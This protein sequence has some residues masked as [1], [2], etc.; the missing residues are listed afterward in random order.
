M[1]SQD[2]QDRGGRVDVLF[3]E[4]FLH[5]RL[6]NLFHGRL[7]ADLAEREEHP[8]GGA[9]IIRSHHRS[10]DFVVILIQPL[11]EYHGIGGALRMTTLCCTLLAVMSSSQQ[12][13]ALTFVL[14]QLF[15]I[16]LPAKDHVQ[17][18]Q[19]QICG[20]QRSLVQRGVSVGHIAETSGD[21]C[22]EVGRAFGSLR[23]RDDFIAKARSSTTPTGTLRGRNRRDRL[24]RSN[25]SPATAGTLLPRLYRGSVR[26]DRSILR[27]CAR[28]RRRF[29]LKSWSIGRVG[30]AG[31]Y[32]AWYRRGRCALGTRPFVSSFFQL[33]HLVVDALNGRQVLVPALA[34]NLR[35]LWQTHTARRRF[36]SARRT[37]SATLFHRHWRRRRRKRCLWCVGRDHGGRIE[38][39]LLY[40][41]IPRHGE[42]RSGGT[43]GSNTREISRGGD[44]IKGHILGF[45]IPNACLSGN[46]LVDVNSA[47]R[48]EDVP[49]RMLDDFAIL[50]PREPIRSG[51]VVARTVEDSDDLRDITRGFFG[52]APDTKVSITILAGQHIRPLSSR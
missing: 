2:E 36:S 24:T 6:A 21:V 15:N 3:L 40:R 25:D 9:H 19:T 4:E 17:H 45:D 26:H 12:S 13:S 7:T 41:F 14:N 34:W 11:G 22:K 43:V 49:L 37:R 20:G 18:L 10:H 35:G 50:G 29:A 23:T 39:E 51:S 1:L 27:G 8:V 44:Q 46:E 47:P 33:A 38:V 48:V 5:K 16:T 31:S 28:R 42:Q 52:N 32:N 30:A